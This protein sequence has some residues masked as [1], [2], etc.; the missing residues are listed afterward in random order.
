[1]SFQQEL[2]ESGYLHNLL[3]PDDSHSA[4]TRLLEK[5]TTQ[6]RVLWNGDNVGL[7]KGEGIGSIA[8]EP[9]L[10][11][12]IAPARTEPHGLM[13]HYTGFG[14]FTATLT[15]PGEDWRP[16]N[17]L[18]CRIKPDCYGY[19][20]P[21][22]TMLIRNDG[23]VK[24]PDV[25]N[26]EGAHVVSLNNHLWN[27]CVWEFPDLPRDRIT[28]FSLQIS[29][30]GKERFGADEFIYEVIDIWLE[31][32][33]EPDVSLGWQGNMG[34]ISFSTSGYWRQGKK[35]AVVHGMKERFELVDASS[36]E[37][38]YNGEVQPVQ[39]EKGSFGLIDFSSYAVC[40]RY[41][42]RV[43]HYTTE[44][45]TIA[46]K[47]MDEA[48][49]KVL[50]YIYS[51][52][53]GA[54]V[55]GGHSSCHGDILAEHNGVTMTYNG[56]WHDAGDLSQQTVQTGEVVQALFELAV[57]V[58]DDAALYHRLLEEACWGLDF[59]LRTRFG[60]GYRAF[61]CGLTRWTNGLFH[62]DDDET[63]RCHNRS[64]DNFLLSGVEAFAFSALQEENPDLAWVC[65]MVAK[66]D[67]AFARKRFDEVGMEDCV[68]MEHT[69]N[70]SLSQYYAVMCW[71]AA[72]IY[73]GCGET[74]YADQ[75]ALYAKR[76]ISCQENGDAGLP[77]RG[78]FYRDEKKTTI[79][80]FN[81]QSREH[82]FVQA[83]DAVCR[84]VSQHSDLPVWERAMRAY[85]DYLKAMY[86]YS[87]PY[88]MLPAGLHA[89]D[90][91]KDRETFP[92][93]HVYTSYEVEQ[94]NYH[95]QLK[96]GISIGEDHCI[97]QFPVWFSFRGNTAV[98]LSAGKA[99]SVCARYFHDH[100]LIE[101]ARDQVYWHAGKNPF[102]Q[103]L[104]YG[105][106]SNYA[107]QYAALCGETVGEL[108]VGIQTREN[109]DV[110][111]WPMATNATYK[112]IW[113]TSAGHWIRL[114]ADLYGGNL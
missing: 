49:Y 75:A 29:C 88:G 85:G 100:E 62:D 2:S 106:G 44:D 82:I 73:A 38:V 16:Y 50:N 76:M 111:Y 47:V 83:L 66:E 99:A 4:E 6:Q 24:I 64:F 96:A 37:P 22:V 102:C 8:G 78:F 46:D 107:R 110:P 57:Q 72:W 104:I 45:F 36:N 67:Y 74:Y 30:N 77:F 113:M 26:R 65:I 105:E 15:L 93:L 12:L 1:M 109:E 101:I 53:C 89:M 27:D 91:Y 55:G 70:A 60:D 68:K 79:V 51:E 3:K 5:T 20:A 14:D 92:Y 23:I 58:K 112:E 42:I 52:R 86:H 48:V 84:H 21:H 97:R 98:L 33:E 54:P 114:L 95:A 32:V 56:G 39:N 94:N 61:S 43:G 41:R 25:Y 11:K 81:H 7:W 31:H 10:L 18:R 17:R 103:S 63:V 40:G 69:Y 80:H 34:T 28:E 19:H 87:S 90:E 35:T 59:I 108:P 71:S 9:P 13:E